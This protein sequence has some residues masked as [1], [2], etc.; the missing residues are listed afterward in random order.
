MKI[1]ELTPRSQVD[2]LI[3]KVLEMGEV[4]STSSG[5]R[6]A[7]ALV[8]D[9]TGV[10]KFTLWNAE[11]PMLEVGKTYTL[12]NGYVT[13]YRGSMRLTIGRYGE[14]LASDVEI[15]DVDVSNN[16]SKMKFDD[17]GVRRRRRFGG[18]YRV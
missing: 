2:N 10:I 13:L 5:N 3:F 18:D 16:L 7:E 6:V 15:G 8:G 17:G 12:K 1:S 9:E 4:R 14:L 11:I